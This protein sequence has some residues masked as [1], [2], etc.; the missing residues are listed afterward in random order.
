LKRQRKKE[1]GKVVT[2]KRKIQGGEL[3]GNW[4][5]ESE[6]GNERVFRGTRGKEERKKI[7]QS[8]DC[9][10]AAT[11]GGGAEKD[12]RRRTIGVEGS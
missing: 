11:I 12:S 4:L 10:G 7:D 6:G 2:W 3:D 9:F 8:A 1:P 5:S